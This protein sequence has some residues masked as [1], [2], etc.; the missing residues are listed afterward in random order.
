MLAKSPRRLLRSLAADDSRQDWLPFVSDTGF[1][2]AF[3]IID[4][5]IRMSSID[6]VTEEENLSQSV[7]VVMAGVV[8]SACAAGLSFCHGRGQTT[9]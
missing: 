2:M 4:D 1:I 9:A 3:D 7:D 5:I 8:K 6:R